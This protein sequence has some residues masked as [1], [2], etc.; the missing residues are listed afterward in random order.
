MDDKKEHF[1]ES[2]IQDLAL[3]AINTNVA[4][5]TDFLTSAE[6]GLVEK[7]SKYYSDIDTVFWGGHEDCDHFIAAFVPL[8][9]KEYFSRDQFPIDCIKI[10]PRGSK[11][12]QSLE[13]R[14]YLGAILNLGMERSKI[15]DIRLSNKEAYVFCQSDFAPLLL[16]ELNMVKHTSVDLIRVEDPEEIP[17][18]EYEL[19][20]TSIASPRLDNVV[21]AATGLS[22]TKAATLVRQGMVVANHRQETSVSYLC[23]NN[24]LMTVRRYG[25]FRLVY[26][27]GDLTKKGKQKITIYKYK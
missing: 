26:E 13:H 6:Y 3:Q 24:S 27:A 12:A 17:P 9:Y 15:G 11:F 16:G 10:C 1:F 5:F 2:R 25:K 21:S 22:R 18:Q 20:S 8:D 7:I 19:F 23:P 14:D 4:V